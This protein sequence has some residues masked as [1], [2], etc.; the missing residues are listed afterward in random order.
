MVTIEEV[1]ARMKALKAALGVYGAAKKIADEYG[2]TQEDAI[3]AQFAPEGSVFK[4]QRD[5]G[6][7]AQAIL[8]A[9][10]AY[11]NA[12]ALPEDAVRSVMQNHK[13]LVLE[14]QRAN[15]GDVL[16]E[17][18]ILEW[19]QNYLNSVTKTAQDDANVER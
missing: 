12:G 9:A 14:F 17:A 18:Q 6:T 16:T 13:E 15:G 19:T 2:I 1:K 8:G 5:T 3:E 4:A 7:I 10:L 11:V